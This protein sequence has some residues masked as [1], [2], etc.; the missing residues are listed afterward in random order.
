MFRNKVSSIF[1]LG[2]EFSVISE[3]FVAK[4]PELEGCMM[5]VQL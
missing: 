1:K 4:V 3:Y 2:A 5:M